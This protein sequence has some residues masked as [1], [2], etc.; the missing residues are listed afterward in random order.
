MHSAVRRR[1]SGMT[2]VEMLVTLS[3]L[4][5]FAAGA[6]GVLASA[7]ASWQ[8]SVGQTDVRQALQ[9][10]TLRIAEE[11]RDSHS[12][13]L[14][15]NTGSLP[16]ALAFPSAFDAQGR[17]V[18]GSEGQP[19]WQKYVLYYIPAG[20]DRLLR[21]E[22]FTVPTDPAAP[23]VLTAADVASACDG[24]GT[25]VA[26]GARALGLA[27][28]TGDSTWMLTLTV[29]ARN[30]NGRTESLSRTVAVFMRN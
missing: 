28:G 5:F 25:L 14:T 26:S 18:T 15:D 23:A 9:V 6:V 12:A 22:V 13:F 27:P 3:I 2:L 1:G 7:K 4:G 20:T 10:G 30:P 16:P 17:F 29:E 24:Q 21:R 8:A 19:V 11:L